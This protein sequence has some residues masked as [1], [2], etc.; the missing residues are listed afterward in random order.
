MCVSLDGKVEECGQ[1]LIFSLIFDGVSQA[2]VMKTA[3]C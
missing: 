2:A 3:S 1:R